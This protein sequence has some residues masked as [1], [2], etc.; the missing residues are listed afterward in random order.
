MQFQ[1]IIQKRAKDPMFI[2]S[3][4]EASLRRSRATKAS[5]ANILKR[6]V[7]RDDLIRLR[8]GIYCLPE[9][10]RKRLVSP[11][12][13]LN[14]LDPFSYVTD[15]TALSYLDLIPEAMS[16]ISAF[17][18]KSIAEQKPFRT[19]IGTFKVTKVP[20]HFLLFGVENVQLNEGISYRIATPLKAILDHAF[21]TQKAW[22]SR[23]AL[24]HDLRLD[25]ENYETINWNLLEE[26]K[27][28]YNHPFMT[29]VCESLRDK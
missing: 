3:E 2:K 19:G 25:E 10:F 7:A 26:Y 6:A 21:T 22:S 16:L 9:K 11:F 23:D 28:K 29:L 4:I 24:I 1:R 18:E 8:S 14:K 5:V 27:E 15:L 13:L 12:E 20:R 17:S